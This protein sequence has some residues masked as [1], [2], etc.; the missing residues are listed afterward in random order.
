MASDDTA[1]IILEKYGLSRCADELC[2]NLSLHTMEDLANLTDEQIDALLF[3]REHQPKK[4]K[5]LCQA[6]RE[7]DPAYITEVMQRRFE[8]QGG[9]LG[10]GIVGIH[11][12]D[13][14]DLLDKLHG[15]SAEL[16]WEKGDTR[17]KYRGDVKGSTPEG[18]G[19]MTW[20]D[21]SNY[22]GE[23]REGMMN[24]KGT[25]EKH[26]DGFL[27]WTFEGDFQNNC[28][29]QGLLQQGND[30]AREIHGDEDVTIF[31]WEPNVGS[32][33]KMNGGELEPDDASN[34]QHKTLLDKMKALG[35]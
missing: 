21:G 8:A 35:E 1:R 15:L 24:G 5:A 9:M 23:W 32:G 19:T 22:R 27:A 10:L 4:L 2:R 12:K 13:V 29:L 28:P 18:E 7:G 26:I 31:E 33:K 25:Y 30:T 34:L 20:R 14:R 17:F 6:C 3:L 16:R 11:I